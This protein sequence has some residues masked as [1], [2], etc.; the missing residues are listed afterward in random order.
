MVEIWM[1]INKIILKRR[2]QDSRK[3][4]TMTAVGIEKT[5]PKA[6]PVVC[7]DLVFLFLFELEFTV[8][9]H[10]PWLYKVSVY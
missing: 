8:L 9:A 3:V 4:N 10:C 7:A 1:P 2:R 6:I 5:C